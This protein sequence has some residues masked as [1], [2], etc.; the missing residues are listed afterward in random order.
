MRELLVKIQE[1][2]RSII[3]VIA[4]LMLLCFGFGSA[5]E[6]Y[7]KATAS[8]IKLLF[9]GKFNAGNIWMLLIFA[10]PILVIL[11]EVMGM[12]IFKSYK[13]NLSGVWFICG[14]LLLTLFAIAMPS[15]AS[16]AWG[17][18]LYLLLALAGFCVSY[19]HKFIKCFRYEAK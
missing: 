12:S 2:K 16:L 10:A 1:N 13:G 4:I 11:Q 15:T 7:G 17:S 19:M 14:F 5:I 3:V 9:N 8:G 18:W 6:V